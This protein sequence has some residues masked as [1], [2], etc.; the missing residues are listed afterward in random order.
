MMF[1]KPL[2]LLAKLGPLIP[3]LQEIIAVSVLLPTVEL[4][5][6]PDYINQTVSWLVSMPSLRFSWVYMCPLRYFNEEAVVE[7]L[8]YLHN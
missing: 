5:C 8:K 4:V 2:F 7:A 6:D 3:F 1:L